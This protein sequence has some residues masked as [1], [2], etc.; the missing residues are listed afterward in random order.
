MA[1]NPWISPD[2]LA[3][4]KCKNKPY[5]KYLKSRDPSIFNEYRKYRNKITHIKRKTKQEYFANL[6]RNASN[7]SDT[8]NF[9]K[10]FGGTEF[11]NRFKKRRKHLLNLGS[12]EKDCLRTKHFR[13]ALFRVQRES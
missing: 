7:F 9:E 3:L 8:W 1:K 2:I 12:L 10:L 6:F 4:I 13:L 11:Q 5:A